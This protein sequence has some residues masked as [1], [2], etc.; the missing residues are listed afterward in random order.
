MDTLLS[1]L[2]KSNLCASFVA[3]GRC[4]FLGGQ[5][6][7]TSINTIIGILCVFK[8]Y[9]AYSI[10]SPLVEKLIIVS[11]NSRWE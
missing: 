11:V 4:D 10:M 1:Y 5:I 9:T 6:F 7:A 8:I 3:P 2:I